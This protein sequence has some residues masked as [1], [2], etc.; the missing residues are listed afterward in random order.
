[1]PLINAL[2][3]VAT[4]NRKLM[5]LGQSCLVKCEKK[6]CRFQHEAMAYLNA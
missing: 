4:E 2:L 3:L 5:R 6:D 1:M